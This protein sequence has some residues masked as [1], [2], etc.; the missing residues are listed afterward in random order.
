[1]NRN[2]KIQGKNKYKIDDIAITKDQLTGRAG[3]ILFVRYISSLGLFANLE[4]FFGGIRKNNKGIS[5]VELFKQVI[6]FFIDGT[7]RHLVY[8]DHLKQDGGYAGT[9]E[10]SMHDMASSHAI[11]RFFKRFSVVYL[12]LFRRVL[13][14]LFI[15]RLCLTKP[16]IIELGIDT[17][18]LDNDDA[19]KRQGVNPTYKKKKGFQPLQMNYGRFFVDAVFRSGEKHSNYGNDVE[20]MIIRIVRQIRKHYRADV[21]IIIRMDSGFFDQ[22]IFDT[23]EKLE[24][25]YI[26][27]GKIYKDVKELA[28]AIPASEWMPFQNDKGKDFWEYFEFGSMRGTWKR[29]R[30]AL[31]CRLKNDGPQLYIPGFRPDTLI[32]TNIGMGQKIDKMLAAAGMEEYL[33]ADRIMAGYHERGCDELANRGLKDFGHEQLPFLKFNANAAWYYT[34]LISHFLF[35]AFKEDVSAGIALPEQS[36]AT[37]V[38]R[39]LIDIPGKV[40]RHSGKV[41]LKITQAVC[42]RLNF[43]VLWHRCNNPM[44]LPCLRY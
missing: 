16:G 26:C 32:Y 28:Q 24:I 7:S 21:P 34:M 42:N 19:E 3:L 37:T 4:A 9:I 8:F 15:W 38:R 5:I 23:C 17:M 1:M 36:Y 2:N 18:V 35:E 29:F 30:R 31:Y 10:T 20:K 25:G 44:P 40:V 27:G 12:Y 22:K 33:S 6:C 39:Q 43:F 11:K 13:S 41:I 14:R